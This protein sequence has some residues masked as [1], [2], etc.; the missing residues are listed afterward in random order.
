[1]KDPVSGDVE[2]GPFFTAG[3]V[4]ILVGLRR[5][6]PLPIALGVAAIVFEQKTE[7]GRALRRRIRQAVEKATPA[8]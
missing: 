4:L 6:R 3:V 8:E 7:P 5:R 2:L 1:V